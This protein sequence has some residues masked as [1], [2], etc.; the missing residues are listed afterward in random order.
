MMKPARLLAA[1][2]L[3]VLPCLPAAGVEKQPAIAAADGPGSGSVGLL[4]KTGSPM[5]AVHLLGSIHLADERIFPFGPEIDRAFAGADRLVVEVDVGP[6]NTMKLAAIVMTRGL[7]GGEETLRDNVTPETHAALLKRL[8]EL[9]APAVAFQRMRP[10]MAAMTLTVLE[11]QSLGFSEEAGI[12]KHF[13]D[14]ARERGMEIVE[15]ESAEAQISLLAG[16]SPELQ[17]L[18]LAQTL[19]ETTSLHSTFGEILDSWRVGDA[20]RIES[21]LMESFEEE[22]FKPI[23]K[24]LL[25]DR[26]DRMTERIAEF[27]E[28][29][30]NWFV[31]LGAGHMVGEKG[32]VRQLRDRGHEVSRVRPQAPSEI[33]G[34]D[35]GSPDS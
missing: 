16:L 10:W 20:G 9:G 30:G 34:P 23:S 7:Y 28:Q 19:E 4:W 15:L 21:L 5:G 11:L 33:P 17:D 8:A 12:D 3:L 22:R 29:G 1:L 35:P 6:Q 24:L 25:E 27:L 13:L 26:N 32:I 18:M 14:R 2:L 31:V